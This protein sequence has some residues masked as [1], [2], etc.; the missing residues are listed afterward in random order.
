MLALISLVL[1]FLNIEEAFAQEQVGNLVAAHFSEA[2]VYS[3]DGDRIDN[4]P[5]VCNRAWHCAMINIPDGG[6]PVLNPKF[7]VETNLGLVEFSPNDPSVFTANPPYYTWNFGNLQV[8]EPEH[9]S[10]LIVPIENTVMAKPR[11]SASRSVQ[12]QILTEPETYQ[13]VTVTFKLEEPL[14]PEVNQL[15]LGIGRPL[16][17]YG[18]SPPVELYFVSQNSVEGWNPSADISQTIWGTDPSTAEVGRTY[19]FQATLKAVKSPD[20]SGPPI[21]KPS[22]WIAYQRWIIPSIVTA[23]SVTITDPNNVI[24]STFSASNAVDW[25]PGFYDSNFGADFNEVTIEPSIVLQSPSDGTSFDCCSLSTPPIFGWASEESFKG[26]EIQFSPD[27]SFSS[28]PVRMKVKV[29]DSTNEVTFPAATWK[30]V[31]TIAGTSGGTVHWRVQGKRANGTTGLSEVFLLEMEPA[32]AVGNP[33][34]SPTSKSALPSLSWENHCGVKFKVWFGSD[35]SFTKK[36]PYSFSVK[37][38]N[39]DEGVFSQGLASAQWKAVRKLVNDATG[40]AIYW[41][42][43]SWDGLSRYSKTEDMYFIL[44]D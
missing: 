21:F 40:S 25:A 5:L 27:Q 44:T 41:Y 17:A 7:Q 23:N 37:N 11:F 29:K 15:A 9:L 18:S 14:P 2:K 22:V 35:G 6:P 4:I 10:V 36:V 43:E 3:T 19:V 13:T 8:K 1:A 12:P 30:K 26:Y 31:L 24:S 38:P 20:L 33:T 42:V 39:D 16:M 32:E 28:I 34:L